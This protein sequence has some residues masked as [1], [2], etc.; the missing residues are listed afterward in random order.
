MAFQVEIQ[1]PRDLTLC[2]RLVSYVTWDSIVEAI[3]KRLWQRNLVICQ[4]LLEG[5]D[6]TTALAQSDI[7]W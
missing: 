7:P 3:Q 5:A 1:P 4:A 6:T 2:C